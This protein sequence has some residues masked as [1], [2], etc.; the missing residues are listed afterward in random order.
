MEEFFWKKAIEETEQETPTLL[1]TKYDP[2]HQ[3]FVKRKPRLSDSAGIRTF[4]LK[5]AHCVLFPPDEVDLYPDLYL[6]FIFQKPVFETTLKS[7]FNANGFSPQ[8]DNQV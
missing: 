2:A 8:E 1:K 4:Q 7:T 6:N 5:N 3:N